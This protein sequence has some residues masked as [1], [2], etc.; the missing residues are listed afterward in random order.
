MAAVPTGRRKPGEQITALPGVLIGP[1]GHVAETL[2]RYR[3]NYGLT[4]FSVLEP[5]MTGFAKVI[6]RLR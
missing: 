3:E 5:H 1:P 4:Y 2:L 6:G